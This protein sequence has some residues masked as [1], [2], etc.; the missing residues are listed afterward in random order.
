M[1]VLYEAEDAMAGA[2]EMD[3]EEL[4]CAEAKAAPRRTKMSD[5]MV[6][7]YT[8]LCVLSCLR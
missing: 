3:I 2:A 7:V 1:L 5:L 8:F 4:L 6:E